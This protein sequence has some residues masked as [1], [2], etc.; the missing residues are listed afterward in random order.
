MADTK[1]SGMSAAGAIT[2]A[3]QLELVQGGV[4]VRST[5]NGIKNGAVKVY[6]ALL[7]QSGTDAP[8]ATALEN[9]LGG[10]PVWTRDDLGDYRATLTGAFP[11]GKCLSFAS[12]DW[13]NST[14]WLGIG[15]IDNDS[16]YLNSK[17]Q[18]GAGAFVELSDGGGVHSIMI[19][20]YP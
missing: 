16:F 5:V 20:V 19:L 3:E 1:I 9:T 18:S 8:V 10:V 11:I 13:W 17:H 4:S 7:S 6:R 12:G 2:G 14:I 15:P